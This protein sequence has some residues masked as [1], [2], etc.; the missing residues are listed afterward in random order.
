MIWLESTGEESSVPISLGNQRPGFLR[1]LSSSGQ[2]SPG[3]DNL[4]QVEVHVF[5]VSFLADFASPWYSFSSIIL[6]SP[7]VTIASS[8]F[9]ADIL[10]FRHPLGLHY[11]ALNNS[12][13]IL[14]FPRY[15][16][17]TQ[18]LNPNNP[19][20]DTPI[21]ETIPPNP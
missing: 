12:S 4:V 1:D 10:A 8:E 17:Q 11:L 18:S 3:E 13:C 21:S 9:L 2:F 6:K 19:T 15:P 5:K 16:H 20:T 7:Q 14:N